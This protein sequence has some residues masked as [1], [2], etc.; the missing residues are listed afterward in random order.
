MPHSEQKHSLLSTPRNRHFT[1]DE[2]AMDDDRFSDSES[3]VS[4][5]IFSAGASVT[6]ATSVDEDNVSMRS[7]SPVPSVMSMNSS[8]RDR[9][10]R[11]EF[12]RNLNNYSA[13]YQLPAD[14]EE[15]DR[16]G[17]SV[18][19]ILSLTNLLSVSERQYEML[20]SLFGY[21]YAPP[22]PEILSEDDSGTEKAILDLGTGAGNWYTQ[23]IHLLSV[24]ANTYHEGSSTLLEIFLTALR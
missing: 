11:Q 24:R 12:G 6:T 14:E 21:K 7:A 4:A 3:V 2:F 8:L 23:A 19:S 13:V 17:E 5:A 20:N 15:L 1:D 22:M 10:F 16:L 18:L 9:L